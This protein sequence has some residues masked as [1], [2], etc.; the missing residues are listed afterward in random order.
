M[1]EKSRGKFFIVGNE[2]RGIDVYVSD[3]QGSDL[4]GD[5][6]IKR[7]WKTINHAVYE[8][9]LMVD[10]QPVTI[11]VAAGTYRE[12]VQLTLR[13]SLLGGYSRKF[14]GRNTDNRRNSKYATTI[15]GQEEKPV[16]EILGYG[17]LPTTAIISGFNIRGGKESGIHC[18]TADAVI[19]DNTIA[20]NKG[21][22]ILAC[23]G[24]ISGNVITN[25]YTGI[26]FCNGT[27]SNNLIR[28]NFSPQMGGGLSK[29]NGTIANNSILDNEATVEGGGLY[30]CQGRIEGNTIS[31]NKAYKGA[32][33]AECNGTVTNNRVTD[34]TAGWLGGGFI[35]CNGDISHNQVT[36]NSAGYQ[37]G[38]FYNCGGSI[39]NNT[40]NN[41]SAR[42]GGGFATC[43]GTVFNNTISG[44]TVIYNGGGMY[45]CS[46]P[47]TDNV[48]TGNR[49]EMNRGGIAFP[50]GRVDGGSITGN[51][52]VGLGGGVCY[53]MA[54]DVVIAAP[55]TGNTSGERPSIL[56]CKTGLYILLQDVD[57][58]YVYDL[59]WYQCIDFPTH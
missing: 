46:G 1:R 52:A 26:S 35:F 28:S 8:T 23:N 18:N 17:P 4:T 51:H 48:I 42:A 39:Y 29:C 19:S 58:I 5:G 7:P 13:H 20:S 22:G 47:A 10:K 45:K 37:G 16:V 27:I 32:G 49:V 54:S 34:N 44:N 33:L 9:W 50:S 24:P 25:N 53:T 15:E 3:A 30:N 40:V 55:V 57:N 41:N 11:N 31:R 38:G 59:P 56:D 14:S 36:G 21:S 12:N 2:T 6:S 43:S